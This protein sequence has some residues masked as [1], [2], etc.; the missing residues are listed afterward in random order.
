M[1]DV[2][3]TYAVEFAFA[4]DTSRAITLLQAA[5][6]EGSLYIPETMPYGSTEFTPE[7]RADPRYQAIWRNDPRLVELMKLRL[8]ALEA[9]Q[10]DGVLP[11]GRRSTPRPEILKPVDSRS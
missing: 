7:M 2:Q 11:D 8:E 3:W 1:S 4:G 10:M 6:N 5:V 9:G